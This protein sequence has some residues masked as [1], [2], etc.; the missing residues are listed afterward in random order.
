MHND[1]FSGKIEYYL[2]FQISGKEIIELPHDQ[3][4]LHQKHLVQ[5]EL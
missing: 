2:E 5:F 1:I 3:Y 4:L